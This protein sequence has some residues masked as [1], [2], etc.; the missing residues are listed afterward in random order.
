MTG[1]SLERKQLAIT[2]NLD[3]V[4]VDL[5]YTTMTIPIGCILVHLDH[6]YAK[7]LYL[8]F[9]PVRLCEIEWFP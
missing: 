6:Q 9:N 4:I 2:R 8:K 5:P 3:P 1:K 7:I